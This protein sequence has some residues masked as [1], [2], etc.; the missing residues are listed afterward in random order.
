MLY[1]LSFSN[2]RKGKKFFPVPKTWIL[3]IYH[4]MT[5]PLWI[6]F[7]LMYVGLF[8]HIGSKVHLFP[9]TTLNMVHEVHYIKKNLKKN[10]GQRYGYTIRK[11]IYTVYTKYMFHCAKEDR[12]THI[13][14]KINT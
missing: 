6:L 9:Q 1:V 2:Y 5:T 3:T 10:Q 12:L 4:S 11:K 7:L 8:L 13:F 14:S